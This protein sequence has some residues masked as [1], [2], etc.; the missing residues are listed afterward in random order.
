[1][2]SSLL[3]KCYGKFKISNFS[4]IHVEQTCDACQYGTPCKNAVMQNDE[5]V[6]LEIIQLGFI[7]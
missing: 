5:E 6:E 4:R 1:M 7:T 2:I 3:S